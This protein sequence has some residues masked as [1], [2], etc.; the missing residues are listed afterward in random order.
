VSRWRRSLHAVPARPLVRPSTFVRVAFVALLAQVLIVLTGS[1]VRLTGSG[2]GCTDWPRCFED[3]TIP[4]WGFHHWVEFGNRLLS[5]VVV[6]TAIAAVVAARLRR[7]YR[8]DL[9]WLSVGLVVGV[10][11][12]AVLG[13][14][15]VLFDLDPRLNIG[16][17]LLSMVLIG[18]GVVLV[19]RAAERPPA[20]P[21]DPLVRRLAA[22][23]AVAA[24]VV[25]AT[26][27][28]VTG[29]GPHAG[30]DRAARLPLELVTVARVH[31]A[32]M[33]VFVA[34]TGACVILAARRSAPASLRR[35]LHVLAGIAVAQGALGYTQYAL[36]VPAGLVSLHI[37][38]AC[39]V[40]WT[41]LVLWLRVRETV[42][43]EVRG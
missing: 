16:H 18:D 11:A 24:A 13:G 30:D 34:A 6:A 2:L 29:S 37:L 1:G 9:L 42:A 39:L 8:R 7:P 43:M 26:G 5:I 23:V 35:P 28:V 27:S 12:Q 41:T 10:V 21:T 33:W 36:G 31:A 19:H 22:V 3:R 38:G 4:P 17:F 20:G 32:S 14:I 25:V 15:L 40:W